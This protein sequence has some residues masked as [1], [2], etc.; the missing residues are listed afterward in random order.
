MATL[1]AELAST[2]ALTT[3]VWS[4][5]PSICHAAN[6]GE[7]LVAVVD[8]IAVGCIAY[9]T[10]PARLDENGCEIKRLFVRPEHRSHGIGRSLVMAALEGA[11]AN[12]DRFAYLAAEPAARP[13]A[14]RT[15]LD[16]GF[17]EYFIEYDRRSSV[18]G[19]VSFLRKPLT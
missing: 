15:Y 16:P 1:F 17:V 2:M 12:G 8:G 11:R 5:K 4:R 6:Y 14:H 18:T 19:F 13:V 9:R 10:L 7:L 3:L